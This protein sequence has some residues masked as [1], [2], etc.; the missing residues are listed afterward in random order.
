MKGDG[1]SSKC[2]PF[3]VEAPDYLLITKRKDNSTIHLV[4]TT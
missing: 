4:D 2:T 3:K 1:D